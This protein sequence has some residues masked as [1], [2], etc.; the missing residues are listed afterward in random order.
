M[1]DPLSSIREKNIRCVLE[2]IFMVSSNVNVWKKI[3]MS[4]SYNKEKDI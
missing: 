3:L 2:A 1:N 4:Q